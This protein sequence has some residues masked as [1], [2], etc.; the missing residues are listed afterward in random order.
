MHLLLKIVRDIGTSGTCSSRFLTV[1]R[2]SSSSC[3]FPIGCSPAIRAD[4]GTI[5]YKVW[6][7]NSYCFLKR[8]H[9]SN[10]SSYDC[11]RLC[12]FNHWHR[13]SIDRSQASFALFSANKMPRL[14]TSTTVNCTPTGWRQWGSAPCLL[15]I[16]VLLC[17]AS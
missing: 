14:C 3:L 5:N 1:T 13:L 12:F 9:T 4:A 7:S 10:W 6:A 8:C 16:L 17:I 15:L 11:M 2:S